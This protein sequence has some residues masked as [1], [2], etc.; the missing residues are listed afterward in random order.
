MTSTAALMQRHPLA[1]AIGLTTAWV[2]L[3][4][5]FFLIAHALLPNLDNL[6]QSILAL[7]GIAILVAVLLTLLGW[8][9]EVG[10]NAPGEWRNLHLLALPAVLVF[11]PFA[12]GIN[13]APVLP[14]GTLIVGYALTGF[15]EEAFARGI[16]LRLLQPNGVL[17]AV[18]ISSLLFGLMHFGNVLI[19]GEPVIIAAQAVGAVCFGVAYAALRLRTATIWPLLLLHALDDLFLRLGGLPTIPTAVAKDVVLLVYGLLLLRPIGLWNQKRHA[20]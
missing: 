5:A 10:F 6:T 19:R 3:V 9:R 18:F 13:P 8:W 4:S 17:R 7:I 14:V 11:L 2:A 16:L 15:A 1:S 20:D 12:G